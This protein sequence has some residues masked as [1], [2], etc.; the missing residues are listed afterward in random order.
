[1]K[2]TF[3]L[4][5]N[6]HLQCFVQYLLANIQSPLRRFFL[7]NCHA[8][9]VFFGGGGGG[10]CGGGGGGKGVG[11]WWWWWWIFCP[12]RNG[13]IPLKI[14]FLY[15]LKPDLTKLYCLFKLNVFFLNGLIVLHNDCKFT[16]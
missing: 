2:V 15:R 10:G 5:T 16:G 4:L 11:G 14:I 3:C 6:K 8:L 7:F 13:R 9:G 12:L 1:M